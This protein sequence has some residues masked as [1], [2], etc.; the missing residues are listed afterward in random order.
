MDIVYVLNT[1]KPGLTSKRDNYGASY[2]LYIL[3]LAKVLEIGFK[4]AV[5]NFYY[6]IGPQY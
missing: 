2:C 3:Y 6:Q 5:L 4:S 1:K